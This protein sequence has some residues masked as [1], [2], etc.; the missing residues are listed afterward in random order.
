[1]KEFKPAGNITVDQRIE[2]AYY[3]KDLKAADAVFDLYREG[4]LFSRLEKAFSV[5]IFGEKKKR[6]LVPDEMEYYCPR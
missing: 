2:K 1:M 3:D 5:G 6:K 4:V